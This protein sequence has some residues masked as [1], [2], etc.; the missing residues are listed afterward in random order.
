MI[1]FNNFKK[2]DTIA[3]LLKVVPKWELLDNHNS[4]NCILKNNAN[5]YSFLNVAIVFLTN[6]YF[7]NGNYN[8]DKFKELFSYDFII[9]FVAHNKDC[10]PTDVRKYMQQA[11]PYVEL[12]EAIKHT[13]WQWFL[14]ESTPLITLD[15]FH[16]LTQTI[17][18][19]NDKRFKILPMH[20]HKRKGFNSSNWLKEES[21][22]YS[23]DKKNHHKVSYLKNKSSFETIYIDAKLAFLI[24]F[25]NKPSITI[26][27][28]F[29]ADKNIYIH[30]I[31][32]QHK[33]RGHYKLGSNWK[34]FIASFINEIFN[35]Y[36]VNI[37]SGE[38]MCSIIS[39]SYS[40]NA[41]TKP[42]DSVL[43]KIKHSYDT[44]FFN[45]N[46]FYFKRK[47]GFEL[48]NNENHLSYKLI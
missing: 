25:N 44:L 2:K 11:Y 36:T 6:K 47:L 33:D 3:N 5:L 27:F 7:I 39:S 17:T 16:K 26:S 45:A 10:I 22:G 42:K 38:S 29:D 43:E 18:I 24:Y 8:L 37:I 30:Q 41:K 14:E 4:I 48:N 23:R 9:C 31:Q 40:S 34:E 28:N 21:G 19:N 46:S 32:A 15:I 1:T 13:P 20:C 35:D 12:L